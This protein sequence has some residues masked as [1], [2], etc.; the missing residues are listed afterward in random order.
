MSDAVSMEAAGGDSGKA[1]EA[2]EAVNPIKEEAFAALLCLR[3]KIPQLQPDFLKKML[4][5]FLVSKKCR[6]NGDIKTAVN[7]W[8]SDPDA[9][10]K[11]YGHISKWDLS[12]V[13][14]MDYLFS[15]KNT[16]NDNIRAWD[17]SRV[18]SMKFMFNITN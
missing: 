2:V 17:V 5:P 7:L 10:E 14:N 18:T 15:G 11:K 9:A 3:V 1:E 12:R 4:G 13:T 6:W 8:C 16:F